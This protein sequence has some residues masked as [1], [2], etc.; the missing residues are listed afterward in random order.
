[1][2]INLKIKRSIQTIIIVVIYSG[3]KIFNIHYEINVS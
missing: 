2:E 1:M 3:I